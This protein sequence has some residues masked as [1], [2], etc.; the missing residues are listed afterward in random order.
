MSWI[1]YISQM[2]MPLTVFAVVLYGFLQNVNIYESFVEGA[3]EGLGTVVGILPTLIGLMCAVE[4]LRG[5]GALEVLCRLIN[6]LVSITGFPVEVVPLALM[7][8]V[9]SSGATG[10]LLDIYNVFGP[11]S[12]T[13][14][15]AS[16]MMGSTETIFYTM[17]VYFMS[18]GIKKTRYTLQ[19]ALIANLA[20]IIC[21]YAVV[22]WV[23]GR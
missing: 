13:G 14:R 3:K 9:S 16:V 12:F 1:I 7:K 23:F 11:D 6:P 19:G 22:L 2:L 15:V 21:T 20:G 17:S 4:V 5:S 18:V 8:A 10:L